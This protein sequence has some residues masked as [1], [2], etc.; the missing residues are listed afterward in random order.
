M[1]D[2]EELVF[3]ESEELELLCKRETFYSNIPV[4]SIGKYNMYFNKASQPFIPE[5]LTW[6]STSNLFIGIPASAADESA[7]R[8]HKKDFAYT[9]VVPSAMRYKKLKP[10]VYQLYKFKNGIAIKRYEPLKEREPA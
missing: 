8:V 1:K 5:A 2:L 6:Y 10:G 3:D 4:V 7:F 9:A